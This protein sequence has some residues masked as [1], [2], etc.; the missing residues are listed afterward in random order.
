VETVQMSV[1]AIACATVGAVLLA[2]VAAHPARYAS[3][4]RRLAGSVVRLLLLLLRAV[5]PPVWALVLLFVLL[6]GVLPGALALG[7]YT[8][9]V[10]GRLAA[11]ATEE[12]D[13]RPRAALTA[14]GAGPVGG[15][16]YGVLPGA[17]GPVLAF[18]LY[19]WEV[20]IRDAVLVGL[21][22]AGGLGALL[23]TEV[24]RFDWG[25]VTTV[26]A[27]L[28]VLTAAVDLLSAR[29]RQALR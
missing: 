22:G 28:I 23:A 2:G 15:W 26:L 8:L 11:E 1:I 18:A 24:A 16:L 10:L 7:V 12:L 14:M 6:P 17:T 27:V 9:G 25:A 5:P 4:P 29:A 20:A 21:L 19:R 3:V 13:P